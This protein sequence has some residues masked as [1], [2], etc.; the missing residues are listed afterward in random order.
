L[1]KESVTKYDRLAEHDAYV[2][3]QAHVR[4][5]A[6]AMIYSKFDQKKIAKER[7]SGINSLPAGNMPVE[8]LNEWSCPKCVDISFY[9]GSY[10]FHMDG[11]ML[12]CSAGVLINFEDDFI[13]GIPYADTSNSTAN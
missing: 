13:S 5:T 10:I 7:I 1:N 12:D 6:K 2:V 11:V 4:K 8:S 9:A 3:G